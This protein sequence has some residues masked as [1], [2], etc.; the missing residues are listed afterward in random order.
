M[1]TSVFPGNQI[2]QY[3]PNG[4]NSWNYGIDYKY[5]NDNDDFPIPE[6]KGSSSNIACNPAKSYVSSRGKIDV[7]PAPTNYD[8]ASL[9]CV[10]GQHNMMVIN[11]A[12]RNLRLNLQQLDNVFCGVIAAKELQINLS[13]PGDYAIYGLFNVSNIVVNGPAGATLYIHNPQDN[14]PENVELPGNMTQLVLAGF[15]RELAS[16]TAR[17]FFV[18]MTPKSSL[19]PVTA[20]KYLSPSCGSSYTYDLEYKPLHEMNEYKA[21]QS[22]DENAL[23]LIREVM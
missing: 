3:L 5:K 2:N 4:S 10:E 21:A 19:K 9:S 7:I 15:M 8:V 23:Y 11:Q 13:A 6:V 18:P 12:T 14:I 20:D 16:T 1:Y 17:N 22:P